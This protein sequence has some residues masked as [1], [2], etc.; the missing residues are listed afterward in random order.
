V[1]RSSG[2]RGLASSSALGLTGFGQSGARPPSAGCSPAHGVFLPTAGAGVSFGRPSTAQ[3]RASASAA[4]SPS[5]RSF[6]HSASASLLQP[7]FASAQRPASVLSRPST[8]GGGSSVS[9][10][11]RLSRTSESSG[12]ALLL[13]A[14]ETDKRWFPEFDRIKRRDPAASIESAAAPARLAGAGAATKAAEGTA[15]AEAEFPAS[16]KQRAHTSSQRDYSVILS[17]ADGRTHLKPIWTLQQTERSPLVVAP[18][19]P[20]SPAL[21]GA[22]PHAPTPGSFKASVLDGEEDP[23]FQLASWKAKAGARYWRVHGGPNDGPSDEPSEDTPFG[24]FV[25]PGGELVRCY[26]TGVKRH[27]YSPPEPSFQ[28]V[29]QLLSLAD[30]GEN[31][32]PPPPR[33]PFPS[34]HAKPPL[35][36]HVHIAAPLPEE[37]TLPGARHDAWY[38]TLWTEPLCLVAVPFRAPPGEAFDYSIVIESGKEWTLD[39]SIYAP[40]RKTCDARAYY[41]T[42]QVLKRGFAL[43]WERCSSA[44]FARLITLE[45]DGGASGLYEEL[46]E[47][48]T[49]LESNYAILSSVY[50]YYCATGS[51]YDNWVIGMNE[52]TLFCD[53]CHI[54]EKTSSFCRQADLD[55]IFIGSCPKD[56]DKSAKLGVTRALLRYQWLQV[57]V[58]ISIAK[59][60]RT[61]RSNDVSEALEMLIERDILPN[62]SAFAAHDHDIFRHEQ[63]YKMETEL[64]ILKYERSLREIYRAY[65]AF[66]DDALSSKGDRMSLDEWSRLMKDARLIDSHF[67]K[68]ESHLCFFWSIS[69]VADEVDRRQKMINMTFVDFLE[70]LGRIAVFKPLPNSAAYRELEKVTAGREERA[71]ADSQPSPIESCSQF[72]DQLWANGGE[73]ALAKFNRAHERDW[74]LDESAQG[75]PLADS[76]ELVCQLLIGRIDRNGDGK[77]SRKDWKLRPDSPQKGGVGGQRFSAGDSFA[78]RKDGANGVF[79]RKTVVDRGESSSTPAKIAKAVE[80]KR[81][82][83]GLS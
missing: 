26:H 31:T 17:L 80:F 81:S 45:D 76:I 44:R 35:R 5:K 55:T 40:R 23:R 83:S 54:P 37:H 73:Y 78:T 62:I 52:F 82:T 3:S 71:A 68:R 70:G 53:E 24:E 22:Q 48:R 51:A 72:F 59:Y 14:A 56:D 1:S 67:T 75:R 66:D 57:I 19:S 29:S 11:L 43:D 8:S 25:L 16:L 61:G 7:R 47:V 10:L 20:G 32:I 36:T 39:T 33:P 50:T 49:T 12:S 60:I 58:R 15:E 69:F 77:I 79:A 21:G 46:D 13:R 6:V 41:T 9:R 42:S 2:L 74:Q 63:L 38:G 64:A 27:S 34:E 4:H 18:V 28:L 65:S 30:M